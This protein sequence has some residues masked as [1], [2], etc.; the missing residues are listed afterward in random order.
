[1]ISTF[2]CRATT[3][4]APRGVDGDIVEEIRSLSI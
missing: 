4:A 3:L 2:F 1:V